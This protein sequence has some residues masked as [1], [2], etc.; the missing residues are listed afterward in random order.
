[1]II[2]RLIKSS[3]G[4]LEDLTRR[5]QE[6][7]LVRADLVPED[8]PRVVA[9]LNGVLTTMDPVSDGWRLSRGPTIGPGN[10]RASRLGWL[11]E[12]GP[13]CYFCYFRSRAAGEG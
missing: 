11:V 6:A 3:P 1:L 12:L 13:F 10:G 7:G 5:A 8:L 4:A 2:S 9:M